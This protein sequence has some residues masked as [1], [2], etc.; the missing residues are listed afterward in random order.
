MHNNKTRNK[1]SHS[2]C[3]AQSHSPSPPLAINTHLPARETHNSDHVITTPMATG[4]VPAILSPPV[5]PRSDSS[6]AQADRR[7]PRRAADDCGELGGYVPSHPAPS[8]WQQ[9]QDKG[10]YEAS[11]AEVIADYRNRG[12][13]TDPLKAADCQETKRS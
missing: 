1:W 12:E 13:K 7:V 4:L 9:H 5:D 3:V 2:R 11:P 10:C 8:A 6:R